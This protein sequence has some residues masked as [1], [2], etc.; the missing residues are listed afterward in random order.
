MSIAETLGWVPGD[1][2]KS[3]VV[4]TCVDHLRLPRRGTIP[5]AIVGRAEMR[6]SFD[7]LPGNPELQLSWIVAFG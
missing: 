7:D 1:A 6:A 4:H 3:D 5:Q 2:A